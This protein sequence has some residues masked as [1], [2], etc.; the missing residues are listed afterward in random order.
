MLRRAAARITRTYV[1]STWVVGSARL[2]LPDTSSLSKAFTVKVFT[3]LYHVGLTN[4]H[5]HKL[6]KQGMF[7]KMEELIFFYGIIKMTQFNFK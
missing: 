5:T 1:I 6:N 3:S 4:K 2:F 7:C